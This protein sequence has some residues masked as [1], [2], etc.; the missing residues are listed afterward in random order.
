MFNEGVV[1]DALSGIVSYKLENNKPLEIQGWK[2]D[3]YDLVKVPS[4]ISTQEYKKK[5]NAWSSF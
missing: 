2:V 1:D 4:D 3:C 5:G